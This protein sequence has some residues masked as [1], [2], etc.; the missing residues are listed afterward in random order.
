VES[1]TEFMAATGQD[2]LSTLF[3]LL[4]GS[5][6]RL[7][8]SWTRTLEAFC[9][10]RTGQEIPTDSGTP[11]PGMSGEDDGPRLDLLEPGF[12]LPSSLPGDKSI[13]VWDDAG[14][15]LALACLASGLGESK[16]SNRFPI[17]HE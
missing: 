3:W 17:S 13:S 9:E 6:R 8:Q 16:R 15:M 5:V 12:D 14:R 2:P 10:L 4:G 7:T 11:P 1:G